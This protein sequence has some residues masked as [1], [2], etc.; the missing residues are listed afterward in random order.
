MSARLHGNL[1]A[2]V[3]SFVGRER[4]LA[5]LRRLL[6]TGRLVTLTGP[7]GVG[8]TRLARRAAAQAHRTFRD[9][10]WVVQL[11]QLRGGDLLAVE[12]ATTLGIT[13]GGSEP[14]ENLVR[15]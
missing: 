15:H 14:V 7:G 5:R 11:A 2:D 9:G 1:Q 3:S 13:D 12:V 6:S 8:K 10:V 4:G